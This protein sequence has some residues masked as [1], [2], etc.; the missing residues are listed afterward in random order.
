MKFASPIVLALTLSCSAQPGAAAGN[1]PI[2]QLKWMPGTWLA[3]ESSGAD[4]ETVILKAWLAPNGKA[5]FYHVDVQHAGKTTPRYDGMYYWHP[6]AQSF[7]IRQVSID[8][9]IAE[10]QLVQ[11]GNHAVQTGGYGWIGRK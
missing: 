7:A 2:E 4:A 3:T 10:G 8:G 5:I 1:Q 11:D 9:R 6:G